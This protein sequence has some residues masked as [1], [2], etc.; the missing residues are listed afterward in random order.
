[1]CQNLTVFPAL[2]RE[3]ALL[4]EKNEKYIRSSTNEICK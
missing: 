1:M 4:R 2:R 3:N